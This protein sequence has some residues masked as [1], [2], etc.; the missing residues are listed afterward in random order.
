MT[1]IDGKV[2]SACTN[3]SSSAVCPTCKARPKQMNNLN[4]MKTLE[5]NEE[6]L[7]TGLSPLYKY[8]RCFKIPFHISIRSGLPTPSWQIKGE[9]NKLIAQQK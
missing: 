8:I 3:T 5:V 6:S 9:A 1:M 7:A 4:L 2:H